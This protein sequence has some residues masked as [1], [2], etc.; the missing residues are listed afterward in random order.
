MAKDPVCGMVID[1]TKAAATASYEGQMYFFCSAGCKS[2]FEE[3]PKK[4][5]E[6]TGKP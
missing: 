1:E 3:E 6:R 2:R 4:Y 5:A